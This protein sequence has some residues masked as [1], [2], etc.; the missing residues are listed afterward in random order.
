MDTG[1]WYQ[2]KKQIA[3]IDAYHGEKHW[4]LHGGRIAG[5]KELP[6]ADVLIARALVKLR[7]VRALCLN[8]PPETAKFQNHDEYYNDLVAREFGDED[9]ESDD[10]NC[11][12]R[13]YENHVM[14][15]AAARRS[16]RE[17]DRHNN[18]ELPASTTLGE[19][20]GRGLAK[21]ARLDIQQPS[22]DELPTAVLL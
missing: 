9:S 13:K 7:G 15:L 19:E 5:E 18:G 2:E 16:E 21:K 11:E 14:M 3:S 6:S 17:D 1:K 20:Q 10:E 8:T 22:H 12:Y 4:L